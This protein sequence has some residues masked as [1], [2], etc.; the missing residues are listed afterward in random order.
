[1]VQVKRRSWNELSGDEKRN[2][3]LLS[4]RERELRQQTNHIE[5]ELAAIKEARS[6]IGRG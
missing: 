6:K 4:D 3:K 2:L 5:S 1:V